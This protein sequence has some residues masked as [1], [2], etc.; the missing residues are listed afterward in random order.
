MKKVSFWACLMMAVLVMA[1]CG[2]KKTEKD[3]KNADTTK[4]VTDNDTTAYGVCMDGAMHTFRLKQDNG[5]VLEISHDVDDTVSVVY[6]GLLDSDELAVTYYFNEED[7]MNIATRVI[8]LT[9]LQA[10]WRSL[11]RDFE[12]QK[13]GTVKSNQQDETRPWVSWRIYNGHLVLNKDT[14]D[15]TKLNADSLQLT[16]DNGIWEY[17]R[18]K[19]KAAN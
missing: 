3:N 15:I 13:G 12:L 6:G 1:G 11:D 17:S 5:K 19:E 10:H 7:Q 2:G 8:N 18:V 16:N 9:T 14:F 4:T